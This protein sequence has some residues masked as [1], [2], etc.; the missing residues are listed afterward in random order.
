MVNTDDV[1]ITV[2]RLAVRLQQVIGTKLVTCALRTLGHIIQ[3]HGQAHLLTIPVDLTHH[4]ATALIRIRL[5][6]VRHHFT[7][8]LV[9]YFDHSSQKCSLKYLSAPSQSTVT[10]TPSRF[11]E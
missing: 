5:L 2:A 8:G 1:H 9:I 7:P 3:H 6:G 4:G 11:A 10:I